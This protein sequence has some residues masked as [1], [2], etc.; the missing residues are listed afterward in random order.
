[1]SCFKTPACAPRCL[2]QITYCFN[3]TAFAEQF[4]DKFLA[5]FDPS[6]KIGQKVHHFIFKKNDKGLATMQYKYKCKNNAVY[7]RQFDKGMRF[8]SE[9]HGVE[10]V[11]DCQPTKDIISK[12]NSGII[13][14]C[15]KMVMAQAFKKNCPPSP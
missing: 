9:E 15:S 13:L 11:P 8:E 6:E 2:E 5:I 10:V 7:P 1:M 12:K 14:L 4:L 3:T